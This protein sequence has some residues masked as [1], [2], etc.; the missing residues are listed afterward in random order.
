MFNLVVG[1]SIAR[2]GIS[3]LSR[4]ICCRL[5]KL[6]ARD[7][8]FFPARLD[9]VNLHDILN[10]LGDLVSSGNN[11]RLC[12]ALVLLLS[13]LLSHDGRDRSLGMSAREMRLE[14]SRNDDKSARVRRNLRLVDLFR[15]CMLVW[16]LSSVIAIEDDL[17]YVMGWC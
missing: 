14:L 5:T 15:R 8:L 10:L 6:T 11:S 2:R 9:H 17:Q 1:L 12:A 4:R 7:H 13:S 16:I 3:A